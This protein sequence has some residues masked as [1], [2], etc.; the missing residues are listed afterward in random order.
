MLLVLC[1]EIVLPLKIGVNVS[2]EKPTQNA[3]T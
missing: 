2:K 3:P 1:S